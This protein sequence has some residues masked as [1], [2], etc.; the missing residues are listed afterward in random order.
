MAVIYIYLFIYLHL[1]FHIHNY[2]LQNAETAKLGKIYF[3]K[4]II[5]YFIHFYRIKECSLYQFHHDSYELLYYFYDTLY[6][7]YDNTLSILVIS[8]SLPTLI[9]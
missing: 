3:K 4:I 5:Y 6:T 7:L 2:I 8:N 1:L 9:I